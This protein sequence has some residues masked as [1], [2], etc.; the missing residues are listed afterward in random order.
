MRVFARYFTAAN[1]HQNAGPVEQLDEFLTVAYPDAWTSF[2]CILP[3]HVETLT[4]PQLRSALSQIC[5]NK[6]LELACP[7]D[8]SL[9]VCRP[10]H[11]L[12]VTDGAGTL[13]SKQLFSITTDADVACLREGDA[14]FV[15][16]LANSPGLWEASV[17]QLCATLPDLAQ[18]RSTRPLSGPERRLRDL[19]RPTRC[20]VPRDDTLEPVFCAA[21]MRSLAQQD[22]SSVDMQN[23]AQAVKTAL[24]GNGFLR[25]RLTP[26]QVQ[27]VAAMGEAQIAYFALPDEVKRT[28]SL[29][30]ALQGMARNYQPVFGYC[31]SAVCS[32]EYFVVRQPIPVQR[33]GAGTA[34]PGLLVAGVAGN[35]EDG[36]SMHGGGEAHTTS[37]GAGASKV[38]M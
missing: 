10:E 19:E 1:R 2:F 18:T 30:R 34:P 36:L 21:E 35:M 38:C 24:V 14:I 11:A 22:R 4:G 13:A 32:K 7:V 25:V 5:A 12:Q 27:H 15:L 9:L 16:A 37:G 8:S 31:A 23:L 33:Q 20:V 26:E 3:D 29:P 6:Q 28:H 17:R